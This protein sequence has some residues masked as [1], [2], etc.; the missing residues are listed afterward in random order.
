MTTNRTSGTASPPVDVASTPPTAPVRDRA[1]LDS[2]HVGDIEGAFGTIRQ[3]E[4][5][6]R[7]LRVTP[8]RAAGD[9]RSRADRDGRR[10]RC[11]RRRHL[12]AGGTELRD[13]PDVGAAAADPGADRQS[14]DGRQAR[15]GDRGRS[16]EADHRALRPLLGLLLGRRPVP[17]QLPDDRHRVH[18]RDARARLLRRLQVRRRADRGGGAD[19]ADRE[20]QL[21][22]L[23]AL[24]VRV[25]GRQLA[26]DPAVLPRPPADR[27]RGARLRDPRHRGRRELDLG[28]VDHRHG[29]NHGRSVAAVLPAVEHHRQ[30]DH[31]A[32]DQLRA[33]RH[34]DRS[35]GRRA[36]RGGADLRVGVRLQGHRLLRPL[37]QRRGDR[38]RTRDMCSGRRPALCSRSC[39]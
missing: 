11:G 17:A 8:G 5:S 33:R 13:Q 15:R 32:L 30:A 25:R 21:P 34:L 16:R 19:L 10:Q 27:R 7:S 37:H 18:R 26:R 39:C 4:Q 36:R 31:A 14:G 28:A 22:L 24:D 20:R 6:H 2:A 1:V 9:H 35:G 38:E 29:R 23:G 12:F 3:H